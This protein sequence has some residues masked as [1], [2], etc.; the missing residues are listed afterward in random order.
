MIGI[1]K[2]K[3]KKQKTKNKKQKTKTIIKEKTKPYF[4]P[5]YLAKSG[6]LVPPTYFYMAQRAI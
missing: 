6:N 2:G 1:G 4:L 5:R 3:N